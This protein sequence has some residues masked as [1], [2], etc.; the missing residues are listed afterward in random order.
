MLWRGLTKR[1]PFC[2]GRG[3]F[4]SWLHM[5][6]AC[7][8]C[9]HHFNQE[10]G[11]YIGAYAFNFAITEGLVLLS[12]IPYVVLSSMNPDVERPVLPFVIAGVLATIVGPIIFYPISRTLWVALDLTVRGGRNLPEDS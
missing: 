9:K 3:I 2:G 6:A 11:F 7:P 10:E 5:K 8:S 4:D 1:C 12:L